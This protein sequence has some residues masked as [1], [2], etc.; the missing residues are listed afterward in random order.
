MT[1]ET[2]TDIIHKYMYDWINNSSNSNDE[3]DINHVQGR[4]Q[5]RKW[6]EKPVYDK[7]YWRPEYQWEKHKNTVADN[8]EYPAGPDN[9]DVQQ[10]NMI[11]EIVR[12]K[13]TTRKCAG[14]QHIVQSNL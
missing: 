2:I 4:P 6:S 11:A 1:I 8:A 5:E 3:R 7:N 13:V 12:R 10:E 9:T 14:Y